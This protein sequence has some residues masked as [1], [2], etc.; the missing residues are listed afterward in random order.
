MA[1]VSKATFEA[2]HVMKDY[3]REHGSAQI[4]ATASFVASL[5]A[6]L[7]MERKANPEWYMVK[8]EVAK[9]PEEQ[10]REGRVGD[11]GGM[12]FLQFAVT[13]LPQEGKSTGALAATL[14]AANILQ[15]GEG[16]STALPSRSAEAEK[17][18]AYEWHARSVWDGS[19]PYDWTVPD[20]E[21]TTK[22]R[23]YIEKNKER[24]EL[25]IEDKLLREKREK[26]A[27]MLD[28]GAGMI[29]KNFF[30]FTGDKK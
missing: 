11:R 6:A 30:G 23:E 9:L 3:M 16:A 19:L 8:L 27:K 28:A 5:K 4:D 13:M 18:L 25:E 24:W 7:A 20:E 29:A 17:A 15:Q 12:G 1:H 2:L 26:R 21:T 14:R 22:L 10:V